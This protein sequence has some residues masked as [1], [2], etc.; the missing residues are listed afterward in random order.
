M[1]AVAVVAVL[2]VT[3]TGISLS[4]PK[5]RVPLEWSNADAALAE[6]QQTSIGGGTCLAAAARVPVWWPTPTSSSRTTNPE[7]LLC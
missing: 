7:L 5:L 3:A 6:R 2:P 1:L 4:Q